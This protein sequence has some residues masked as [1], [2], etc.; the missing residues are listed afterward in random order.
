[1]GKYERALADGEEVSAPPTHTTYVLSDSKMALITSDCD[2]MRH[3][4]IK[5]P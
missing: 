2:A 1:M 3:L 4:S 5:W